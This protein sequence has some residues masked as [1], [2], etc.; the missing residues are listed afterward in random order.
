VA[1]DLTEVSTFTAAVSVPDPGDNRTAAS[2]V[3]PLQAVTNRTRLF[4]NQLTGAASGVSLRDPMFVGASPGTAIVGCDGAFEAISVACTTANV[5]ALT[6]TGALTAGSIATAGTASLTGNVVLG[7]PATGT[8]ELHG[9]LVPTTGKIL[10]KVT[11]GTDAGA[12]FSAVDH[13][14]VIWRSSVL[15]GGHTAVLSA[16]SSDGLRIKFV[17]LHATHQMLISVT[18]PGS[19]TSGS[20]LICHDGT[21]PYN[22]EYAS[23]GGNWHVIGETV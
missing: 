1:H 7:D 4:R 2:V 5:G 6:C 10:D 23:K 20:Q 13:D 9:L 15:T 22:V 18:S 12:T 17:N 11:F 3:T 21:F 8:T 19:G 16:P 14:V